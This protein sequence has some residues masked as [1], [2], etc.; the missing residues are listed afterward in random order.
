MSVFCQKKLDLVSLKVNTI[1][2]SEFWGVYEFGMAL[3]TLSFFFFL[4]SCS[5]FTGRLVW[6]V[7]YWILLALGWSL[8]SVQVWRLLGDL[9]SINVPWVRDSTMV[10][11]SGVEPPASGFWSVSYSSIKTSLCT[12]HRK[13]NPYVNGETTLTARNTQRDSQNYAKK[14]E[15]GDRGDQWKK[16]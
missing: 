2:I 16:M 15:E 3:S 12:H 13:Q 6:S 10:Q 7:L 4:V 14:R 11:S 5:F 8:V 1:S 9:S